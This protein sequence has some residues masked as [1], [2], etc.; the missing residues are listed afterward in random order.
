MLTWNV[1]YLPNVYA[2]INIELAA[3]FRLGQLIAIYLQHDLIVAR[4]EFTGRSDWNG[5]DG[6]NN[7]GC[8]VISTPRG[9]N[10]TVCNR[11]A[12]CINSCPMNDEP[13]WAGWSYTR[14]QSRFPVQP[15]LLS[16]REAAV[17]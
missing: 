17:V 6:A 9:L 11:F 8:R 10:N 4:S 12:A 14:L 13:D 5:V 15:L 3:N 1:K 7:T 2:S 16:D